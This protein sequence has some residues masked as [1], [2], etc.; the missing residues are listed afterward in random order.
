MTQIKA[1]WTDEQVET[2]NRYQ[3]G[4]MHPFTCGSLDHPER[5]NLSPASR[6]TFEKGRTLIAKND[7]W[8]CPTCSYTQDWAWEFMLNVIQQTAREKD[9]ALFGY[10]LSQSKKK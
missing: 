9:A 4:P 3:R 5:E 1:P 7:G 2:L 8:H 6:N 10:H